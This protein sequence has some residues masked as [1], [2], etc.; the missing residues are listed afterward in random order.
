MAVQAL[1]CRARQLETVLAESESW[2]RRLHWSRPEIEAHQ[3]RLLR[4]LLAH[5]IDRSPFHAERLGPVDPSTFTL[6]Q[7][8]ELPTMSKRDLMDEFDRVVTDPRVTRAAAEAHLATAGRE[9][10]HLDD[11]YVVMAS[12]GSSGV[13]GVFVYDDE[14]FTSFV[15]TLV[16]ET[17]HAVRALG[18]T[19]ER[20]VNGAIVAAGS[21][22]HATAAVARLVGV[23]PSPVRIHLAPATLPFDELLARL[24]QIQPVSLVAYGSILRRL[25]AAKADGRLSISPFAVGS[26]SEPFPAE[27][28]AE[29]ER[30]FGVPAGNTFGS[31]EGL[32]GVAPPG[33]DA[34][35]F[36]EDTSIIELVDAE[37]RPVAPGQEA[38]KV[39]LTNLANLAQPLIRYELT[40][41]FR[42]A[43]GDWPDGHLRAV[44]AGRADEVLRWGPIAIH[45]LVVR[46]VL[47]KQPAVLEHQVR[48][49]PAGLDVAVVTSEAAA[50]LVEEIAAQLRAALADAGLRGADVV[51]RLVDRIERDPDT[52]K[53]RRFIPLP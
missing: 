34:I 32:V 19:A 39:Y 49:T 52:G 36:A 14:G 33:Q 40:D 43:S 22:V 42:Q 24:E 31:T 48:Q 28:R 29:V 15:L 20:P 11:A 4:R 27:L 35:R 16:R 41:R 7:L 51:V 3:Q 18:V 23:A 44:V 12:G 50:P 37:G 9:L 5:A 21:T 30:A 46:S 25:A 53:A 1:T 13:R 8:R 17:L 10:A 6:A 47:V 45:P 26:T 2:H 38:A